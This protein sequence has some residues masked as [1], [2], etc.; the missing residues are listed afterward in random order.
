MLCIGRKD[1]QSVVIGE[2]IRVTV[3]GP[4]PVRMTIEAPP[5]VN[6]RR[7]EL[8]PTKHPAGNDRRGSVIG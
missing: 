4:H 2:N 3:Y 1:G 8:K 5:E 6:I 7:A